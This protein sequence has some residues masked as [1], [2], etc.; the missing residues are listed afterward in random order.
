MMLGRVSKKYDVWAGESEKYKVG[1]RVRSMMFGRVSKTHSSGP[2]QRVFLVTYL[3]Q[4]YGVYGCEFRF[5]D[6]VL[7]RTAMLHDRGFKR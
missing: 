3:E 1:G 4:L 6:S 7:E 5:C 2:C